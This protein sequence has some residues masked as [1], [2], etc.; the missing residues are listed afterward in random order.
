M[1][2]AL[3]LLRTYAG[4]HLHSLARVDDLA[5]G[6]GAVDR[7][8]EP[9][10]EA[11]AVLDHDV[12]VADRLDVSGRGLEVVGVDVRPDD[13]VHVG[14][15]AGDDPGEVGELSGSGNHFQ[16]LARLRVRVVGSA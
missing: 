5:P 7:R 10:L 4:A 16:H 15:G 2:I 14:S 13:V 11:H 3:L 1:G 8:L 6:R 12:G 9:L